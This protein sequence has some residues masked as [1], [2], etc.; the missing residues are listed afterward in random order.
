[1]RFSSTASRL[2]VRAARK[3]D[4]TADGTGTSQTAQIIAARNEFANAFGDL[5][6]GKRNWQLVTFG[7]AIALILLGISNLRLAASS[8]VVPYVVQVDRFGQIVNVGAAE[9]MK[10]PDQRLISSQLAQF[11]RSVRTV[12]PATAAAAQ[13]DMLR[14]AYAFTTPEAGAFLN[15]Y[16][17]ASP[18]D[19]RLLG[20]RL[21]RQID[22]TAVLPVPNSAVWRLRWTETERWLQGSAPMRRT[23]WEGYVTVKLAAPKTAET[24]QDN[25]LGIYV[26]SVTWTQ[27][28][29]QTVPL[30]TASAAADTA[31]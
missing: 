17:S 23:A 25:P 3:G 13:A 5:A 11:I 20:T 21:A 29:E 22:V 12:L 31:P 14:R 27:L 2:L 19:P 8:R 10:R 16:F 7:L 30:D 1:M 18:N 28:A 9:S 6:R 4:A 24:V 15:E 26:A